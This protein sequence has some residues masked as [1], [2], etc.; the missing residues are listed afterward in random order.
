MRDM[1]RNT[2][3]QIGWRMSRRLPYNLPWSDGEC[4]LIIHEHHILTRDDHRD[5]L[6]ES[7]M[8]SEFDELQTAENHAY[9][10]ESEIALHVADR[11]A[12]LLQSPRKVIVEGKPRAALMDYTPYQNKIMSHF[13]VQLFERDDVYQT[14]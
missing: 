5:M 6:I 8:G 12:R 4:T 1:L 3:L 10:T 13:P 14:A 7:L 2:G 11:L 9:V